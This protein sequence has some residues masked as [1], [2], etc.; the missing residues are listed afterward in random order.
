MT[1]NTKEILFVG[2]YASENDPGIHAF[3]YNSTNGELTPYGSYSGIAK[4]SFLVIHPNGEWL[5]SVS[6]TGQDSDGVLGSVHSFRIQND[7]LN[8]KLELINQQ[9]TDGDWPCHLQFDRSGRWLIASN[10]GTG[11]AALFPILS[12]GALG[13][14]KSFVQHEGKGPNLDRQEGPHAHSA[15]FTPDNRFVIVADLGIDQLVIYKFDDETGSLS[16]HTEIQTQP[17]AGPRHFAFH[18]NDR[19]LLVANELD[20]SVTVYEYDA[21]NGTPHLLQTLPTLPTDSPK[22][23]VA[24]IHFSP[25]GQYVYVSNR[26]HD[27]LAI[28]E[29]NEETGMLSALQHQKTHGKTPRNFAIDPNGTFLQTANQDSNNIATFRINESTGK[30][31]FVGQITDIPKPVC[32]KIVTLK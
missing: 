29:F 10:Y 23:I 4:P 9:S 28:F 17:G 11:N 2:S 30:L 16:R 20:S 25:T 26:G 19:H 14:L 18:P 6:E 8:L 1:T 27:S 7:D 24:D 32:L 5:Y 31:T 21:E 22:S 15:I 12:D 3:K 13:E